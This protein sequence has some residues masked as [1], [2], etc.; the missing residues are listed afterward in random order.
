MTKA[1]FILPNAFTSMNFLLGVFSICWSAGMFSGYST[2]DPFRMAAYFVLLSVLCDKLDGF[3]AR[4]V[5]ASSEFGAQF[6]SLG[7][8][9]G[10]GLAPAFCLF[11][12]YKANASEWLGENLVLVIIVF[13]IYVLCAAMRLAKYNA[14]DCDSYKNYFSGLPSTFAGAIN[15]ILLSYMTL[16]G[17]FDPANKSLLIIPVVVMLVSGLMMVSPCF[18]PKLHPHKNKILAGIQIILV[19]ITYLCGFFFITSDT[20]IQ[21]LI[22]SYLMLLCSG[23]IVIGFAIGFINRTKILEAAGK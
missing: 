6:D 3:A 19:V 11:F 14:M 9:V 23:Y 2:L 16:H 22:L 12:S 7:D 8:L 18:L 20:S 13:A 17:L 1:R 10:F 21:N 4:L 5:N 15:V